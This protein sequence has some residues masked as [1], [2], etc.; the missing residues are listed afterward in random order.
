MQTLHFPQNT[1]MIKTIVHH[2]LLNINKTEARK[3]RHAL[4]QTLKTRKQH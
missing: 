4:L 1:K 3:P 2:N